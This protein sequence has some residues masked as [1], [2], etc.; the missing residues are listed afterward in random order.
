MG[1]EWPRGRISRRKGKNQ[2]G[3][4]SPGTGSAVGGQGGSEV[5]GGTVAGERKQKVEDDKTAGECYFT[6]AVVEYLRPL[7]G[8]QI[9]SI[10][11]AL[12]LAATKD[13][14][15]SCRAGWHACRG[16]RITR[17]ALEMVRSALRAREPER[18]ARPGSVCARYSSQYARGAVCPVHTLQHLPSSRDVL[19]ASSGGTLASLSM[20]MCKLTPAAQNGLEVCTAQDVVYGRLYGS[21]GT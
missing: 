10:V 16:R 14:L 2:T 20:S 5:A 15:H 7:P 18:W 11:C 13:W 8:P 21:C 17:M 4:R 12:P 6:R 3:R 19:L 1:R 9:L